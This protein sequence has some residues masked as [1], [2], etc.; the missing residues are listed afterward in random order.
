[1]LPVKIALPVVESVVLVVTVTVLGTLTLVTISTGFDDDT[2]L[3]TG[4]MD[5]FIADVVTVGGLFDTT[6]TLSF[7]SR[8]FVRF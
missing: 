5:L 6:A 2:A 7:F 4:E 8:V 3:I 1:M